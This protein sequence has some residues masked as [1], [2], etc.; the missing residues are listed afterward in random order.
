ME[1]SRFRLTGFRVQVSEATIADSIADRLVHN[2]HRIKL[3]DEIDATISQASEGL[4]NRADSR[5]TRRQR[6]RLRVA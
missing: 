6:P 4:P 1:E 3:S 5:P 2:A